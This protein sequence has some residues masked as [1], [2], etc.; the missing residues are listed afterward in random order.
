[1]LNVLNS[2]E[3]LLSS[4][5]DVRRLRRRG[6]TVESLAEDIMR[7]RGEASASV[8]VLTLI[9]AY[10]E[11][12]ADGRLGFFHFLLENF[13][14]DRA[15]L[16]TAIQAYLA[17]PDEMSA[18]AFTEAAATRRQVL[19]KQIHSVKSGTEFL[20]K[21]REDLFSML[22]KEP[23]L[24]P[25]DK[26][27]ELL[28][29]FWFSKGF[30]ELRQ[31]DWTTPAHILE[32]L[33]SYE[34][35]HEIQDWD[36]LRRRLQKDRRCFGF[37]HPALPDEPLIFVEVALVEGI[38]NSIQALLE[39]ELGQPEAADTA[40]FYSISNCHLGLRSV[41]FGD[42]LLKHVLSVLREEFPQLSQFSTLS[43]VPGFMKWLSEESPALVEVVNRAVENDSVEALASLQTSLMQHCA[44]YLL[45]AKDGLFPKDPVARFHLRNGAK[46][47][48]LH[49][50]ADISA[51][52]LKQSAGIM[53]NYLYDLSKIIA[54]HEA[55]VSYGMVPASLE[56]NLMAN[57]SKTRPTRRHSAIPATPKNVIPFVHRPTSEKDLDRL[58]EQELTAGVPVHAI[59]AKLG[60]P[61]MMIAKAQLKWHYG[62]KDRKA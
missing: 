31:L 38:S 60:V 3:S 8:M 47:H 37:F 62:R 28:F 5:F 43:P 50:C 51:R 25:I 4:G 46:L 12:D 16:D 48:A 27:F 29:S 39:A 23:E 13:G 15:L 49:W 59:C 19:F 26:D 1:M 61:P 21:L 9:K 40:I 10:G 2:L 42:S 17:S 32:K 30:L 24:K 54:N 52:G 7:R 6:E 11:L 57:A 18:Q 56:V 36:D 20:I 55:F 34:A 35:V 14:A 45:Y 58:I 22:R 53:V 33:I 44:H 41:S